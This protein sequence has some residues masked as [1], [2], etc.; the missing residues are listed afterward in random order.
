MSQAA[1]GWTDTRPAEGREAFERLLE[2]TIREEPARAA[3]L[4]G[5]G[6]QAFV[7]YYAR[8]PRPDDGRGI[9]RYRRGMWRSEAGWVARWI[10]RRRRGGCPVR[11]LDAGAGFGTYALLFAA[12]GAEVVGADLRPDRL[13]VAAAR[14]A[15]CRA[16]LGLALPVRF[17]RSDLTQPWDSDFDLVWVYN[18]LSHIDPLERFL[19]ETRRHLRPAGVLAIGDINGAHPGH[20]RRLSRLRDE[21]HQEY[22]APDGQR[23]PYAVERTFPPPELRAELGAH[24]FRV[25]HHELYWGGQ[26]MLAAPLYEGVLRPLQSQWW[27]GTSIAR[28]QLVVAACRGRKRG[29]AA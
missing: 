28:R 6:R 17:V 20:L 11:V 16:R 5:S 12:A 4:P 23:S 19:D 25:V 10:A 8:L 15:A 13:E 14:V 2:W 18:A 1:G 26:G 29:A 7:D 9:A 21:V 24:G 27:L 22:V 3:E